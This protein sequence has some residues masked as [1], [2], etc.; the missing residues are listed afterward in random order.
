MISGEVSPAETATIFNMHLTQFLESKPNLLH[1]VKPFYKHKPESMRDIN[2]AEKLK[3]S[4]DKKA[5]QKGATEEDKSLACQALR[6]YNYLLQEESKK[7]ESKDI[8]EQE[9]AYTK[10]F[11]KFAKETT[12]GTHGKPGVTPSYSK[13]LDWFPEVKPP[14][15]EYNLEPYTA[16]DISDTLKTKSQD[17][18]P[19][20][21]K[22][23]YGYLTKLPNT[24]KSLADIFARIRDTSEAPEIWAKS[25]IIL[26]PK[27]SE[28]NTELPSDFRMIALTSNVG[29]LF[30][31]LESSRTM[32]YMIMNE[33]LNPKAQKLG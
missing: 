31:T 23:L 28:T 18:A 22:I 7:G 32:N 10:N 16:K 14:T 30:H 8:K 1:E 15:I 25:K 33:Y 20:E 5:K 3:T 26:I 21:D 24:H 27:G 12:N 2:D 6:H 17:S 29:K 4:L 9:K 19:G 11:F 13:N